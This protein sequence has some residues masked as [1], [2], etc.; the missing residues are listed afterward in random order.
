VGAERAAGLL[1][2]NRARVFEVRL[3]VLVHVDADSYRFEGWR[4]FVARRVR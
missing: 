3:G 2:E 1:R 4:V